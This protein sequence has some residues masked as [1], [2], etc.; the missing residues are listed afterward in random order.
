MAAHGGVSV[1]P[2]PTAE[3]FI[4]HPVYAAKL[5]GREADGG[6]SLRQFLLQCLAEGL[7]FG[8]LRQGLFE[9]SDAAPHRCNAGGFQ[10]AAGDGQGLGEC[11]QVY[12]PHEGTVDD[13]TVPAHALGIT[14][15]FAA[16]QHEVVAPAAFH[17]CPH[18]LQGGGNQVQGMLHAVDG[19]GY[20]IVEVSQVV[21]DRPA[22]GDAPRQA[23]AVLLQVGEVYLGIDALV[24]AH[25]HGRRVLPQAKRLAGELLQQELVV[26]HVPVRVGA[27]VNNVLHAARLG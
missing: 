12:V 27:K 20:G 14:G 3:L 1:H 11:L 2:F 5:F 4:G 22:A 23:D 25:N 13:Y 24:L 19:A 10:L 15:A 17:F 8:E 6:V 26:R 16:V 18:T 9:V 7:D 21:I